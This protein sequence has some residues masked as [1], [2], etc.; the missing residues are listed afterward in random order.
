M[1]IT[2]R[3]GKLVFLGGAVGAEEVLGSYDSDRPDFEALWNLLEANP[4]ADMLL[5]SAVNDEC[6][7]HLRAIL[8]G[9][10]VDWFEG[11]TG[12]VATYLGFS[13]RVT[14]ELGGWTSYV[15]KIGAICVISQTVLTVFKTAREV[16]AAALRLAYEDSFR[17]RAA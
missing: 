16:R 6:N 13:C 8:D 12:D 5:A 17:A 1:F 11:A 2:V 3:E 14:Q 7:E 10:Y 4:A 9:G 15:S